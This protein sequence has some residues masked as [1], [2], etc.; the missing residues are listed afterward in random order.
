MTSVITT[1]PIA[2]V[3]KRFKEEQELKPTS[4]FSFFSSSENSKFAYVL[5]K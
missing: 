1:K 4:V 2:K 5:F 3:F